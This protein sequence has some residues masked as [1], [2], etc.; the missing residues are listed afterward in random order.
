MAI[1]VSAATFGGVGE[2]LVQSLAVALS[3]TAQQTTRVP[4][5]GS[6]TPQVNRGY[7]RAKVYN[8]GGTSPTLSD[9][10]FQAADGTNTVFIDNVHPAAAVA[11]STTSWVDVLI[12][13]IV[14]TF[15]TSGGAAGNLISPG[16]TFFNVLT[17]MG[18]TSPT[19]S[20]DVEIVAEP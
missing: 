1:Q 2:Q 20:M 5:S 13:F 19:A 14:D 7:I 9:I 3:G 6:I 17:T 12:D 15:G 11:L 8:G 10:T 16:A 4:A 18:G